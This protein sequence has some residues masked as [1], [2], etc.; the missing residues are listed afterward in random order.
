LVGLT[1]QSS[2][3]AGNMQTA[4]TA[5]RPDLSITG[6]VTVTADHSLIGVAGTGFTLAAGSA[7]NLTGTA[8]APL[9]PK[10]GPLGN[11]G[12]PTQTHALLAGSPALNT[13]ANPAGLATDQRGAGFA[14]V[15]GPAADIGAY[16]Y[17]PLTAA[18]TVNDGSAQRS[19]VRSITVTFSGPVA[20][21]GGNAA[22]AFT[23]TRTGPT[24]PTGTVG[25]AATVTTDG[26]GRTV[27][28]LTFSGAFTESN[29]AAGANP[30]LIDGT[31]TLTASAAAVA[32]AAL[33]WAVDGNGD[34]TPGGNY[35]LSTHRLFGDA[36]GD[37]DVDLLDLSPLV[38]ALFGVA[39]Q[40][41][42]N[43]AFDFEGDGDVDLADLAAF[44]QRLFQ[45]GY[46]P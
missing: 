26:Q 11:Y 19:V 30:S 15:V 46:T 14:R 2:I 8:A 39:G 6:A 12:G 23:L 13:G 42:Y 36:D 34:G 20:F 32:D 1:L 31:Y 28:K 4:S 7:N 9:D 33:G 22:A 16:E 25:L 21:A 40:P 37:G 27:V 38:P 10:L 5:N 45:A 17:R 3:V 29:T 35:S 43:P 24:G 18:A 41:N 44:A